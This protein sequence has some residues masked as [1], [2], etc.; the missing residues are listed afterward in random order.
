MGLVQIMKHTA[1]LTLAETSAV[2]EN[3]QQVRLQSKDLIT[4]TILTIPIILLIAILIHVINI[5][6]TTILV[7]ITIILI[8]IFLGNRATAAHAGRSD[9]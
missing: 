4:T 9:L 5:I 1:G 6:I 3:V 2:F 7:I 8:I